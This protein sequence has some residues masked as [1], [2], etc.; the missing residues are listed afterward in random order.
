M[1]RTLTIREELSAL[2]MKYDRVNLLDNVTEI[3]KAMVLPVFGLPGPIFYVIHYM[4]AVCLSVSIV[5]SIG[6]LIYLLFPLRPFYSRPIGERL[7]VYLAFDDLF[8]SVSHICDHVYMLSIE[9]HP[10]DI[11]CIIMGLF[12]AQ[13]TFG[14]FILVTF[15]AT[16]SFVMVVKEKKLNLG[17]NDWKLMLFAMGAP[18]SVLLPGAALRLLGPSGAW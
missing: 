2:D 15:T 13:F 10:P 6:V 1:S 17:H 14:Q 8:Y 12:I 4:A 18:A 7:V 3:G 11:P 9:D 5:A 16:N